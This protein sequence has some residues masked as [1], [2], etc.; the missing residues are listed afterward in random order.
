MKMQ[1]NP[2]V[3]GLSDAQAAEGLRQYGKNELARKKKNS[4]V[5]IFISQF[6]DFLTLVLLASTAATV[7]MGEYS[8]AITIGIII[9][10]NS[11]LGFVQEYKTE[12]TLEALKKMAAPKA[13]VYRNGQLVE[14]PSEELVPE[15]IISV[16]S[17]DRIPAD[18]LLSECAAFSSD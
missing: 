8:E 9:F 12:K 10:L 13:K 1:E 5:K 14:R 3:M 18:G 4:P 6:K 7:F 15:D 11:T 17:G 2:S 16:E